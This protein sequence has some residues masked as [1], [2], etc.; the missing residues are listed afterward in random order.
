MP[1]S[2]DQLQLVLNISIHTDNGRTTIVRNIEGKTLDRL[3]DMLNSDELG[4]V[5]MVEDDDTGDWMVFNTLDQNPNNDANW[6][7]I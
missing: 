4:E 3:V 6:K 7:K 1:H 5:A 2:A